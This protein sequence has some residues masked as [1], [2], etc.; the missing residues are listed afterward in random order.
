MAS[1]CRFSAIDPNVGL[2]DVPDTRLDQ[3]E[4]IVK[5]NRV[6][7][8]QMEIVDIAGLVERSKPWRRTGK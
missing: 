1:N 8:T 4:E 3:L 5:P 6:V 2:V 7:P